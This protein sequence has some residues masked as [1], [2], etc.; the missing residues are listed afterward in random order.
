MLDKRDIKA[1]LDD[2]NKFFTKARH[3]QKAVEIYKIQEKR[4][5]IISANK[6]VLKYQQSSIIDIG[7]HSNYKKFYPNF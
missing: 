1:S 6:N 2:Y 7:K 4:K 5:N 3:Y